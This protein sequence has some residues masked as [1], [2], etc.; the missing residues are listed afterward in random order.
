MAF[1][2]LFGKK[3]TPFVDGYNV[4]VTIPRKADAAAVFRQWEREDGYYNTMSKSDA[5]ELNMKARRHR[6]LESSE[7]PC[8]SMKVHSDVPLQGPLTL[9]YLDPRSDA[10]L[11]HTRGSSGIALPVFLLW[12]PNEKT[13]QHELVHVSQKQYK[14]RWWKWY[15]ETWDFSI[16]TEDEIKEVPERWRKR[17]RINPDTLDSPYTVWKGRYIPLSVFSSELDPDLRYCRRGFWDLHMA[18]WT[19]ESPSGWERLFGRGFNDEHPHEIAA[20]WLDGSGG[21]EKREYFRLNPI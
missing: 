3:C 4:R 20:H 2:Y 15:H 12:E 18:Q 11:P 13:M 10:G 17:R 16:A 6:Y 1:D 14:D 8:S 7:S 5:A 21:E 19:W 9:V